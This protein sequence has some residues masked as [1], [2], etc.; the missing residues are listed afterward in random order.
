MTGNSLRKALPV[1][2]EA[3]SRV[4]LYLGMGNEQNVAH[5]LIGTGRT[6]GYPPPAL[7][8]LRRPLWE[9]VGKAANCH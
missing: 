7:W 2:A 9:R 4:N 1:D 6:G 8:V 3:R 5:R